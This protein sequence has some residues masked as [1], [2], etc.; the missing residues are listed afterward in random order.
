MN[1][2]LLVK[3]SYYLLVAG[4][5]A[6]TG[7]GIYFGFVY[8]PRPRGVAPGRTVTQT[9]APEQNENATEKNN[10]GKLELEKPE[11][12][13]VAGGRVQW[14]V[15]AEQVE[16][17]PATGASVLHHVVGQ[18]FGE[19]ERVLNFEAPLTVYDPE[20]GEVRIQG[21]FHGEVGKDRGATVRG[22]DLSWKNEDKKLSVQDAR[23]TMNG[24]SIQGDT[25]TILPEAESI[26]FH[27]HVEIELELDP[28]GA[29]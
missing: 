2:R 21:E 15:K 26:L 6:G 11:I 3:I 29:K 18:V 20:A 25:M 19:K 16:S 5:I 12:T 10:G 24:T 8:T 13:H 4:V 9:A 14:Q 28:P 7:L 17:D 27:G 23:F 1:K 22:R